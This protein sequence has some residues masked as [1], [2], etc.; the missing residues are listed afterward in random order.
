MTNLEQIKS[1]LRSLD[2]E[3][4]QINIQKDMFLQVHIYKRWDY[5]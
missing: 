1:E 3:V 4:L 2:V 5:K